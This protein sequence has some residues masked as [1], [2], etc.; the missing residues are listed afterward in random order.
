VYIA[1]YL[2]MGL[3]VA[4]ARQ[5]ERSRNEAE[6]ARMQS[7]VLLA[8][9]QATHEQLRAHTAQAEELAVMRERNR[10]ARELHDSV[11]QSLHSSTLMA[12]AGQRLA[13]AG[14][15]ERTRHYLRRLGEISQQALKE[16]RLLVYELRPSS[17]QQ[18]GLESAL[19]QR[20]VQNQD[21]FSGIDRW[22]S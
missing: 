16:M 11:T 4:M 20:L 21:S 14:D 17:L 12:E 6:E 19:R 22:S 18:E 9:L 1:G 8:E 13:G 2:G 7:E 5:V 3:V 15:L 10:L